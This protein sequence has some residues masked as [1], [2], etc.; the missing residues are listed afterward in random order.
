MAAKG[1]GL[2]L[3]AGALMVGCED[4]PDRPWQHNDC[5]TAGDL[6]TNPQCDKDADSIFLTVQCRVQPGR[7]KPPIRKGVLLNSS[8]SLT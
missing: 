1:N 4:H 8:K 3:H 5:G 2:E 7:R 6:C